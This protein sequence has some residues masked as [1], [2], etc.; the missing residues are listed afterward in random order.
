MKLHWGG[1]FVS[2]VSDGVANCC[3]TTEC[4]GLVLLGNFVHDDEDF[5]RGFV[6]II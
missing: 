6:A 4:G 3:V 2:R 1:K 5:E